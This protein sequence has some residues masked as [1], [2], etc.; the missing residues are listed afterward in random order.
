METFA[1]VPLTYSEIGMNLEIGERWNS[2]VISEW[3]KVFDNPMATAA[4]IDRIIHHSVILAF[5]VP[6]YRTD[7]AR[8]RRTEGESDQQ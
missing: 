2:T 1:K 5:N 7:A 6:R 8:N 4:T 3:E